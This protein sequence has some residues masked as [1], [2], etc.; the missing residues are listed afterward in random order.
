MKEQEWNR[1]LLGRE[2]SSE[3]KGGISDVGVIDGDF[4]V[5]YRV[6]ALLLLPPVELEPGLFR[7]GKPTPCRAKRGVAAVV[8]PCLG[9][10]FRHGEDGL[11]FP[12]MFVGYSKSEFIQSC[13]CGPGRGAEGRGD[14]QGRE[15][16]E[17]VPAPHI[18][19]VASALR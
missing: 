16:H 10:Y 4:E 1:V 3:V 11:E 13:R 2:E 15:A 18:V 19:S 9:A 8:V 5:G 7:P 12:D 14:C 6:N 17:K